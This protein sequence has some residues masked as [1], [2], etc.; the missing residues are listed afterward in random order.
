MIRAYLMNYEKGFQTVF[1]HG[2]KRTTLR[3]CYVASEFTST[4]GTR[5]ERR[6]IAGGQ[7]E[8]GP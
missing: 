1:R 6:P 4:S 8:S 3:W 7:I 5:S 2:R